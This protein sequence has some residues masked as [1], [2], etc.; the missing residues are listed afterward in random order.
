[1]CAACA[2]PAPCGNDATTNHAPAR[3]NTATRSAAGLFASAEESWMARCGKVVIG[4][5]VARQETMKR[6]TTATY[7]TAHSRQSALSWN[8][9]AH[10]RYR[11]KTTPIAD[12]AK[13]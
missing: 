7:V 11:V 8:N 13:T 5:D 4:T 3:S 9:D 10:A 1:S 2:P 12:N 6:P